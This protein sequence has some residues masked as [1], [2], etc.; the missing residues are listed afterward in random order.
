MGRAGAGSEGKSMSPISGCLGRRVRTGGRRG[1]RYR[2]RPGLNMTKSGV[3]TGLGRQG[4]LARRWKTEGKDRH[5]SAPSL[6]D[7]LCTDGL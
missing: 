3:I 5:G 7:G 1:S 6:P 2:S 4:L